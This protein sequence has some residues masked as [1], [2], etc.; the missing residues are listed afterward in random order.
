MLAGFV[1]IGSAQSVYAVSTAKVKPKPK[2][3]QYVRVFYY[4]GG[5]AA[6]KSFFGH[7]KSVD[8]FAPQSYTLNADGLLD[9]SVGS[10]LL[11]FARKNNI[12]VM[13]LIT[14]KGFSESGAHSLLDDPARQ[15]AAIVALIAEAKDRQYWGWQFDFEQMDVSYRD[16]YSVFI[17][18]AG[19]QMAD[20][21]L[22]MSVA[23]VADFAKSG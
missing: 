5:K 17:K 4:Q 2:P 11:A 19:K 23:V 14:N 16:K 8:V 10:D 15:N 20:H 12:K 1:L 21:N 18:R 22:A 3:Y 13:P 7:P 9:G 6:K